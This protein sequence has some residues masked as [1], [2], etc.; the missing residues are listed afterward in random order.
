M[1]SKLKSLALC[2]RSWIWPAMIDEGSMAGTAKAES[3]G[4]RLG[5]PICA[6][7]GRV[8]WCR[9]EAN[10]RDERERERARSRSWSKRR[11]E[12]LARDDH[13]L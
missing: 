4:A 9:R 5:F 3:G 2:S 7:N 10:G 12:G 1:E 8:E 11:E 6:E 13:V